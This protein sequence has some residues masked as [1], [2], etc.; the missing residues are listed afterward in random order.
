MA[1]KVDNDTRDALSIAFRHRV[2]EKYGVTLLVHQAEWWAPTEGKVLLDVPDEQGWAVTLGD[3]SIARRMV[4]QRPAGL[5]RFIA[6]LGAF[7]TGKSFGAALWSTGFAVVPAAR[8]QLVGMEYNI[9]EPEFSYICDFLLSEQGMNMK[10]DSM[11]NNPRTGNMWIDFPNGARYEAKSW[12]RKD[13]LKGK[14]IDAYI[15]CEAY[16]LPG[17]E[18]FTGF[19]QNLRARRGYAIFATT[20]DRPWVSVLHDLG[21]EH[22]DN[23]DAEWHCTCSVPADANPVTFDPVAKKRDQNLMTKEKYAIHYE[24]KL[25]EYVG[26]VF[27]YQ[28]GQR[29]FTPQSHPFLFADPNKPPT[30]DNLKVPQGYTIIGGADTGTYYTALLVAFSPDGDAFVID[31]FPNYRYVAQQPERDEDITIPAW[32]SALADRTLFLGGQAA[33]W[34]DKNSQFKK[35]MQAY[36]VNLLPATLPVEARTEV[37]RE[38]FQANKIWF[39]PWLSVLPFEV[40][41]ASWPEEA[42]AAGKFARVKDRDH[43]LDCL[44]HVLS[45]RP[46]GRVIQ[47]KNESKTWIEGFLGYSPRAKRGVDPHLGKN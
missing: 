32:A 31:E 36:G 47:K 11:A 34:A 13:A 8:V 18:C 24:G 12:E 42:S 5:A 30:R 46:R 27:Q 35:E 37:A 22:G 21:H 33:Y 7:K 39:A 20:P 29:Q 45:K 1:G 17:F 9:C 25:G 16:Q 6:D 23:F 28:R 3:G 40:E 4:G 19:S 14:E 41:N 2:A 44:E 10:Y 15:Y 43:T 26:R 38:Y